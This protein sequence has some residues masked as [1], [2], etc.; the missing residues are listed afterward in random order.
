MAIFQHI[1]NMWELVDERASAESRIYDGN[2][3]YLRL[4]FEYNHVS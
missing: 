2:N 4:E 1:S 3:N